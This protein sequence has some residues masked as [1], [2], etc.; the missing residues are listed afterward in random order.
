M[1]V[2]DGT[3]YHEGDFLSLDGSTGNV[4]GTRIKTIDPE[5]SGYFETFMKWVDEVRS[6]GVR[7][8]ADTVK[9]ALNARKF[10]AE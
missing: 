4:Y 3:V 5:I 6:L 7:C 2:S 1:I 10:G 8:N 9:D